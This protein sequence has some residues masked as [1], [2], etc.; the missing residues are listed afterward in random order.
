MANEG[1]LIRLQDLIN[2]RF[3]DITLLELALTAPGAEGDKKGNKA[4]RDK[5]DGNRK[6]AQLG[7][8]IL[9]IIVLYK[10]LFEEDA[11]RSKLKAILPAFYSRLAGSA[12]DALKSAAIKEQRE[13]RARLFQIDTHMKLSPRQQGRASTGTLSLA[14][15]AIFGA[16]FRDCQIISVVRRVVERFGQVL[17]I[18]ESSGVC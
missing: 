6:L 1:Y 16:C 13:E 7:D 10:T 3:N 12:S 17:A 8:S 5:Y 15:C 4:E 11:E 9:Q 2:Y 14:V 18:L